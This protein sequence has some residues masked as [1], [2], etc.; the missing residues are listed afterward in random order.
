MSTLV[1]FMESATGSPISTDKDL[2]SVSVGAG[3]NNDLG[4]TIYISH[5]NP[6]NITNFK[7]YI[8]P[9][10]GDGDFNN[11]TAGYWDLLGWG[12]GN[13]ASSFGGLQISW[14][15]TNWPVYNKKD[16]NPNPSGLNTTIRTGVGDKASTAII[17]PVDV[18][19]GVATEGVIPAGEFPGIKFKYRVWVPG[20]FTN[21][22]TLYFDIACTFDE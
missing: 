14:D 18:G 19:T 8:T 1:Y 5:N 20:N 7:L 10:T 4:H 16:N 6:S 2:G 9:Y 17:I 21:L 13:S 22:T 11:K 15:G 3:T 12:D